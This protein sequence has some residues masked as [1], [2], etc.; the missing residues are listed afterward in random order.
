MRVMNNARK[1]KEEAMQQQCVPEN[2]KARLYRIE[3]GSNT[4]I[5]LAIDTLGE[6]GPYD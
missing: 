4:I 6:V 1:K 3:T 5:K 2:T